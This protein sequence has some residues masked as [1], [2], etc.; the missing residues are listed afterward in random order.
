MDTL[1]P[2]GEVQAKLA[3]AIARYM[4]VSEVGPTTSSSAV[5]RGEVGGGGGGDDNRLGSLLLSLELDPKVVKDN[6]EVEVERWQAVLDAH[7]DRKQ[8]A[9][10]R[11]AAWRLA[12]LPRCCDA[13][14]FMRTVVPTHHRTSSA[15]PVDSLVQQGLL[16]DTA[17]RVSR[18][19]ALALV[20]TH[21][22]DI[23]RMHIADLRRCVSGGLSLLELRA[24]FA[25]LPDIMIN[26]SK[27]AL[28]ESI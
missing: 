19:P 21:P 14:Q 13:L 26:D 17:R 1:L 5:G 6:A 4:Q 8:E 22:D 2:L 10:D 27:G 25:A 18:S 15:A 24:V 11:A 28:S 9:A 3:E 12:E 16:L 7:P 23:S 20:V